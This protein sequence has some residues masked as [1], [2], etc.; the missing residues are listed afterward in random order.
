MSYE[1]PNQGKATIREVERDIMS[2]PTEHNTTNLDLDRMTMM[3]DLLGHP[4]DSFRIIHITGTNGKGSTARMAEAI[5][6]AYGMRTGLYTSPHLERINERIA[7]DGQQLGDDDFIDAWEQIRDFVGLVDAAMAKQGKPKM[8]FFEVLTAMAIWKFADAPV[9][10]AVVE[11]GMGGSWDATNVLDGDAAII[12]P[13]DMDHMQWLGDTVEQIATE[14]SG[15]IKPGCTAIIGAQPHADKV[16][17]ILE[18]A[19]AK[20]H[21]TLVRDGIEMEVVARTL[22]VG[23]Q[24]VTM[25]TPNGTYEDVPVAKFGEHQAHNALAALAAAETV[26]PVNGVLDGDLVAE[27]LSGVKIPGRIEQI[28]TSPTIILDGGHNLNAAEALRRAIEEN[29]DFKQLVGVIAMME[30]KQVEEY[31]GVLEPL[32]SHVVVTENSW[33]ERVMPAEE[34]EKIAVDVFGRDRVTRVDELPDAIQTAV[35][36]VDV[37]D[38]L[39]VG[40][41]HGVLV[42]GSFVTA[43]D[44]RALLA[45][46]VDPDLQ[47]TKAERVHQPAVEPEPRDAADNGAAAQI[48]EAE[49]KAESQQSEEPKV[50]GESAGNDDADSASVFSPSSQSSISSSSSPS[51]TPTSPEN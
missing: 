46:H 50:S 33:R 45:E 39:G 1:H 7:I 29:Y 34:L 12:G 26:I 37:E 44:A 22:A 8:S 25:R 2:R 23:G 49:P 28:R 13:V 24:V 36:M 30:D 15:I 10:V 41:G 19:A 3:L 40:Y 48:E 35:D 14:K 20:N 38:E 6:R 32:L 4:E 51:S 21:A 11:V 18:A 16:M 31:L 27:G 47:R 43:G 42:A 9:D 17:P 5:C